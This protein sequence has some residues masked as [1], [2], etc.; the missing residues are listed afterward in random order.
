MSFRIETDSTH[1]ASQRL[2]TTK[3]VQEKELESDTVDKIVIL[4][5][6]LYYEKPKTTSGKVGRVVLCTGTGAALGA[7]GSGVGAAIGAA[8]G[9]SF[10]VCTII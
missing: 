6:A 9:F 10:G 3:Y 5:K 1:Y 8:A 2:E 7:L 4:V